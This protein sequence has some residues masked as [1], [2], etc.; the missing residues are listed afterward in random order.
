MPP[1]EDLFRSPR[2]GC[3]PDNGIKFY[4]L[5]CHDLTIKNKAITPPSYCGAPGVALWKRLGA[6][7]RDI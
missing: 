5:D 2:Y 6:V 1:A 7:V 3:W 4:E